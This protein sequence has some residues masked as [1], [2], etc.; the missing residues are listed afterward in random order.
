M[1]KEVETL[2]KQLAAEFGCIVELCGSH[3]TC[4]P[5]PNN[6]DSEFDFVVVIPPSEKLTHAG[7]NA[8]VSDI[9]GVLEEAGFVWEGNEH[10]QQLIGTDF[11]SFRLDNLNLIVTASELFAMRHRAATY[12]CTCLNLMNKWERILVFQAVL[13]GTKWI[14][15]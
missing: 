2:A 10:Y 6:P 15:P 4:N 14:K 1:I 5:P 13:Y 3:I 9:V 8:K 11:M 7:E 12:V